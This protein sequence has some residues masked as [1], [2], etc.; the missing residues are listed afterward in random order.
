MAKTFLVPVDGSETAR[1]ALDVACLLARQEQARLCILHVPEK[2]SCETTL[3]W[4]AGSILMNA[5]PTDLEQAGRKILEGARQAATEQGVTDVD[6][7]IQQGD[8][9]RVITEQAK[10]LS[11]DTIVMGSR[12]LSDIEGLIVGSVSHKVAHAANCQVIV[13]H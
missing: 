6:V 3:V 8:P 10:L 5:S 11:V 13:V 9:A 1:K 4:D 12:G 2:V 7:S